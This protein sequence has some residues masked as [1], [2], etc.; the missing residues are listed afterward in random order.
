MNKKQVVTKNNIKKLA[1]FLKESVEWLVNNDQGC[2][3]FNLS[4]D[5]CVAVGWS[6]GW[7]EN[8]DTVIHS[9]TD[10]DWCIDQEIKVRNDF[11]CADLEYMNAPWYTANKGGDVWSTAVS[12]QPNQS[13]KDFEAD[14]EFFL[15]QFVEM[16]NTY[17]KKNSGLCFY[18]SD[19]DRYE[20]R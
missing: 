2:C 1:K 6:G 7:D 13:D 18:Q 10:K 4:E 8:D 16:T 5:L 17:N 9:R 15:G 12:V 11:D 19:E 14:A 20:E 3:H